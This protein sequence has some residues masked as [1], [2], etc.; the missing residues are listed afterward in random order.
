ME[1]WST[2][3]VV[4]STAGFWRV[5]EMLIDRKKQKAEVFQ[6][7]SQIN[8]EI[9]QNWVGWSKKLE[10]RVSDLEGRNK[11]MQGTIENQKIKIKSLE[12]QLNFLK[13]QNGILKKR[14][15]EFNQQNHAN[16]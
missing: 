13:G 7:Q 2:L 12:T 16:G 6:L 1:I 10:E 8:S 4:I 11:E 15:E 9:V 3:A 5:A 14:I